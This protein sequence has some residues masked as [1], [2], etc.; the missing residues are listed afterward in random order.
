MPIKK[1][2]LNFCLNRSTSL[3]YLREPKFSKD[4]ANKV[5]EEK[6]YLVL[7]KGEYMGM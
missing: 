1:L 3:I 7:N 2:G 6:Y 5:D 4:D